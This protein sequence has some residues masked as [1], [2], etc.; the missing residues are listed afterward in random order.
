MKHVNLDQQREAQVAE[1][2]RS[3]DRIR[4]GEPDPLGDEV[5]MVHV[6]TEKFTIYTARPGKKEFCR[7]RYCLSSSDPKECQKLRDRLGCVIGPIALI[8]ATLCGSRPRVP[9]PRY[10]LKDF[11]ARADRCCELMAKAKQLAFDGKSEQAE[12]L[13]AGLLQEVRTRRDSKNRMRYILANLGSLVAVIAAWGLTKRL[14]ST[15]GEGLFLPI[16]N[17]QLDTSARQANHLDVLL[18]G[19]VGAFFAVSIGLKKVKVQHSITITEMLYAGT[20]RIAIGLIAALVMILLF[21]GQ[22]FPIDQAQQVWSLYLFGFMAGFSEMLIPNAL[23]DTSPGF[24]APKAAGV[25]PG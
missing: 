6:R 22:F 11:E 5:H 12:K 25:L 24:A 2:A 9:W 23:K 15:A 7:L 20:V 17:G 14:T 10:R 21:L 13:L 3:G 1:G 16:L 19:A 4:K 8:T 18:L